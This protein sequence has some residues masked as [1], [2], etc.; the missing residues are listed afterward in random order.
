MLV[1]CSTSKEHFQTKLD[2]IRDGEVIHWAQVAVS[3]IQL[4]KSN[5]NWKK[6]K[7]QGRERNETKKGG[8][9]DGDR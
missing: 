7:E 6:E 9:I 3:D 2:Y 5:E 1:D 8:R 4:N